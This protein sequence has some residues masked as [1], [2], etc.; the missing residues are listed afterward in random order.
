MA[1][2]GEFEQIQ[3]LLG[4]RSVETAK[5]YLGSRQR[6]SCTLSTTNWALSRMPDRAEQVTDNKFSGHSRAVPASRRHRARSVE[7]RSSAARSRAA[8]VF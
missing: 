3:F 1:D 4:H 6:I 8:E 5:R 7:Y 2:G